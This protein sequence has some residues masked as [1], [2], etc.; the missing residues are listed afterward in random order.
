M[1]KYEVKRHTRIRKGRFF[2]S[3]LL[4]AIVIFA[5][6]KAVQFAL[7]QGASDSRDGDAATVAA[8]SS[9]SPSAEQGPDGNASD[10]E[11]A[12][13]PVSTDSSE[14][15]DTGNAS[16]AT[17]ATGEVFSSFYYYE[18]DKEERYAAYG[19]KNPEIPPDDV[20]W[21]VNAGL[22]GEHY[23][24]SQKIDNPDDPL[25]IVNKYNSL[26]E[27]YEPGNRVK[28]GSVTV[29]P[30]TAEAY[31]NMES[32]ATEAGIK[33]IAQ[34]GYRSFSQQEHLY[35]NY[36]ASDPN[37]ADTY[38]ARPGFSE[39]QTGLAI[40]LNIPTGGSLRNFTGT[41]Q[42]EWVAA[43]AHRFGFIVRYTED[44]A[45]ITGYI[46][47]PWHIRFLGEEHATRMKELGIGSY[48]EYK[49][50][51]IDHTAP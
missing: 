31:K 20:V 18:A 9:E 6:V 29:R 37:G 35:T 38:S 24:D 36:K 23:K 16:T 8:E 45:P 44:N 48:E 28:L 34:S 42:A 50:K 32:A 2:V 40:D 21:R 22:D 1:R 27:S 10:A 25:V 13:V 4:F 33:F 15:E 3:L 43:N 51:F 19:A 39:H 30:E 26:P 17:T 46:S 49:V 41:P 5:G 47:E 11:G 14:S 12:S 7:G